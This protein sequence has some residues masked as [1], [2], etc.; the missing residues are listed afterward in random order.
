MIL[1]A[2]IVDDEPLAR[3][4]LRRLLRCAASGDITVV[5]E[6]VD[7]EDVLTEAVQTPIDVL[8]L[9]IE[10]PGGDGFSAL[11]RWVGTPPLVVFVTAYSQYGVRAFEDR[12]VDYLLKPVSLDRLLDAV[13][14]LKERAALHDERMDAIDKNRRHPLPIGRRTQFVPERCI[15]V[16]RASGN[17][18]HIITTQGC[19]TI[20]RT[21]VD[22][23]SDLDQTQF[24]RV[25][26]STV[27]RA[28][29]IRQVMSLGS[30]RYELLLESGERVVSGRNYRDHVQHLTIRDSIV[31]EARMFSRGPG[32]ASPP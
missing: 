18:L 32:P 23:I 3:G 10:L 9:D 17:Y 21:L 27:V 29:A 6:C 12:A 4:R 24:V 5:V 7:V 30:G 11:Q 20:R 2:A 28:S 13:Q 22:F 25:H 14:R 19:F 26:R 8:F 1:R 15:E 31:Q 16:V